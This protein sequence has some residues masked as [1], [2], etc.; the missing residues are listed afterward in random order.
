VTTVYKAGD[1]F[2]EGSGKIYIPQGAPLSIPHA[3]PMA[4][5]ALPKASEVDPRALSGWL[6]LAGMIGL[7]AGG[8]SLWR[9]RRQQG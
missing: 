4:P 1:S 8:W 7:I 5:A 9:W 3:G 6:V 2:V